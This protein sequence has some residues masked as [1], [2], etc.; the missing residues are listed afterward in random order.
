MT[1][2]STTQPGTELGE[3]PEGGTGAPTSVADTVTVIAWHD[4]VVE[5]AP[6]AIRTDSDDALVWYTPSVGTIGMAMAHRFARHA[7]DGTSCWT[8][9]DVARTFG[10]GPSVARVQRSLER[11]ERFGIIRRHGHAI[12]VRLWLGPLNYRQRCG[13]PAYLAHVY[14]AE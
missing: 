2:T 4:P 11:L 8:V 7:A 9:E 5:A 10:L 12:A 1:T 6:G 14:D 3:R 13:L